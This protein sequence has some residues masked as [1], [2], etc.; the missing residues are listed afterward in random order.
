MTYNRVSVHR[1]ASS[2]CLATTRTS[3]CCATGATR[4]TTLIASSR[5]WTRYLRATG[6]C[7]YTF[8]GQYNVLCKNLDIFHQSNNTFVKKYIKPRL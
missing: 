8:C 5:G 3:C 2:A 6:E 4:A 1:T 7:Y